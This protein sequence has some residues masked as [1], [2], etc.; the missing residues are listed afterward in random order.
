[1]KNWLRKILGIDTMD[2]IITENNFETQSK[3]ESIS[4]L[5]ESNKKDNLT[6]LVET[7]SQIQFSNDSD[8][9]D[10]KID[11]NLQLD[12]NWALLKLVNQEESWPFCQF[13]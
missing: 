12:E 8:L 2:K 1:M 11:D 9:I 10:F 7:I 13:T 3:L 4:K 5:L 6:D